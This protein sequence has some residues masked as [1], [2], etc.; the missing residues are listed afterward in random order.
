MPEGDETVDDAMVLRAAVRRSPR[1]QQP[2]HEVGAACVQRLLDHREV[3]RR[4]HERRA[5]ATWQESRPIRSRPIRSG[6]SARPIRRLLRRSGSG[7]VWP[8]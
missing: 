4:R 8:V 1:A 6:A 2:Q 5:L 7:N 3:Q